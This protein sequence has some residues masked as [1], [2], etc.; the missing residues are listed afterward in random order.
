MDSWRSVLAPLSPSLRR[1]V[2]P[3]SLKPGETPPSRNYLDFPPR[4]GHL[5]CSGDF[6]PD[7][8][9]DLVFGDLV[10]TRSLDLRLLES[11]RR[12]MPSPTSRIRRTSLSAGSVTLH[13][14]LVYYNDFVWLLL[15]HRDAR[16]RLCVT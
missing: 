2:C 8:T 4:A 1:Q 15:A 6:L 14:L 3:R 7:Q 9:R 16:P 13:C 12:M 5:T 11:G 10:A